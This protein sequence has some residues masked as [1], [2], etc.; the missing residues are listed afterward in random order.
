MRKGTKHTEE[1]K[2]K[3]R[4]AYMKLY[5]FH[6]EKGREGGK[7]KYAKNRWIRHPEGLESWE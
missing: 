5:E 6:R 2:R 4:E 1:T 7:K 3:I